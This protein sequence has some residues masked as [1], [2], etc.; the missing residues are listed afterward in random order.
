MTT[1]ILICDDDR[2]QAERL[3]SLAAPYGRG[4]NIKVFT[5][6]SRMLAHMSAHPASRICL[7]DVILEEGAD[8]IELAQK[9]RNVDPD[10]VII[11]LS[12]FL[13]KACD[14]YEVD[15]CWFIYKPQKEKKLPEALNK[16]FSLL[17][18]RSSG[19][20][21]HKGSR[22]I[23]LDPGDILCIERIRRYSLITCGST[24]H[25]VREDFSQLLAQLPETFHQ[26]HRS[27][28]VNF[29]K[30]RSFADSE[31]ELDNGV[32]VP[33][34]RSSLTKIK[35]AWIRYLSGYRLS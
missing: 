29:E 7:L 1:E 31:F 19:L 33:V 13:E 21:V 6:G 35:E 28:I 25:E 26:C 27:Y 23:K 10:A 15:H 8:G 2:N 18:T 5:E 17:E 11:F 12:G 24:I 9:I 32:R 3:K 16:A 30:V 14:V 20:V 22:Y 34:A 4:A